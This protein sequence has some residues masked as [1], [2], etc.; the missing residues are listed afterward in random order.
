VLAEEFDPLSFLPPAALDALV[1]AAC[2]SP[3]E[4]LVALPKR[5]I[6]LLYDCRR[7]HQPIRW[8]DGQREALAAF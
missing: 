3:E 2:F 6:P 1:H 8:D 4:S 5:R 7:L